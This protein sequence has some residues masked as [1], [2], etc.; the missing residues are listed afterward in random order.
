MKTYFLNPSVKQF[1]T[2]LILS[3][4][5][6][7]VFIYF[8]WIGTFPAD[9]SLFWFAIPEAIIWFNYFLWKNYIRNQVPAYI[10][11]KNKENL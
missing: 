6:F 5:V 9:S 7:S 4:I 2:T 1:Y 11:I 8:L 10:P 3:L